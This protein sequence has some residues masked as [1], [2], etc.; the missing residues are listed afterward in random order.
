MTYYIDIENTGLETAA[1][2]AGMAE[3]MRA[4]GHDVMAVAAGS[5]VNGRLCPVNQDAWL[6]YLERAD[7]TITT[8]QLEALTW[9]VEAIEADDHVLETH[10]E[11][12]SCDADG[13]PIRETRYQSYVHGSCTLRCVER[14]EVTYTIEWQANGGQHSYAEALAF[15]V[16]V[17][18]NG[19][20]DLDTGSAEIVD[21]EGDSVSPSAVREIGNAIE[22]SVC[23]EHEVKKQLPTMPEAEHIDTDTNTD[24][25]DSDMETIELSRDDGPD[26]R[27]QGVQIASASSHHFEGPRNIR[28]TE[29]N[30]Y[31]TAGGKFVCSEVGRTRW[32]GERDRYAVHIAD[33]AAGLIE[34]VGHGWLAKELYETAGIDNT[35][36]IE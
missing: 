24:I 10:D 30:L 29:L 25:E 34:Q 16:E 36:I 7:R 9:T 14:P 20:N 6:A 2:V 15:D 33:S 18:P 26:V 32:A 5:S 23:W 3:L 4:D 27:F 21:K 1:K 13:E 31:S 19:E 28:W 22:Q 8:E 11:A 12:V 17:N 35:E